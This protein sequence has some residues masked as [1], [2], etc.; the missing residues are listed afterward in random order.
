ML[1]LKIV[2]SSADFASIDSVAPFAL[3][4]SFTIMV[5]VLALLPGVFIALR[6]YKPKTESVKSAKTLSCPTCG[7]QGTNADSCPICETYLVNLRQEVALH[8]GITKPE[9]K[10]EVKTKGAS[11]LIPDIVDMPAARAAARQ[12][13]IAAFLCGGLTDVFALLD[14]RGFTGIPGIHGLA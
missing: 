1:K 9:A 12:G 8:K 13:M 4:P 11:K 6:F 10:A 5:F 14:L 7:H 3:P 2:F